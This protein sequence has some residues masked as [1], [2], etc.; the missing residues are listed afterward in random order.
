MAAV[1]FKTLVTALNAAGFAD[2]LKGTG[3]LTVFAPT[4]DAFAYIPKADLDALL[5]NKAKLESVPTH[6]IFA[7]KVM[8]TAV[9]PG[10]VTSVQGSQLK[11]D[12]MNGVTVKSARVV[13]ADEAA[14]N[15]VIHAIDTVLMPK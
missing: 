3:Q 6:R 12:T 1:N 13:A 9:K 4:D 5:A 14:D 2:T 7:G 11:I 8:S 10:M 15:G